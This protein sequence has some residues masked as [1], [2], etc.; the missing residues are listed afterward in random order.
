ML[1][2]VQIKYLTYDEDGVK[3]WHTHRTKWYGS[4]SEA[5]K[6]RWEYE[7]KN[8]ANWAESSSAAMRKDE[9]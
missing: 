1:Y 2:A 6:E 8:G 7:Q 9:D 5:W 3:R 4:L